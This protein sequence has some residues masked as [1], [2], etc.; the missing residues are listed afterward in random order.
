MEWQLLA[1]KQV[2]AQTQ[3]QTTPGDSKTNFVSLAATIASIPRTAAYIVLVVTVTIA[4]MR[5]F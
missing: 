4:F 2:H 5:R 3:R 1:H